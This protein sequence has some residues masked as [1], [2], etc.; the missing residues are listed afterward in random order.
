[1]KLT[2]RLLSIAENCLSANILADVGTDH[3]YIPI[4]AVKK[5][6]AES[7]CSRLKGRPP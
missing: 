2:G 3:G 7:Y 4:Y 5:I 6:S 1:M